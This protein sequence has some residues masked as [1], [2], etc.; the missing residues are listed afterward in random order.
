MAKRK[1]I[2]VYSAGCGCCRAA[3]DLVRRIAGNGHDV[4]VLNMHE[5]NVAEQAARHAISSVP[6]V[7]VD[8]HLAACCMGRDVDENVLRLAIIA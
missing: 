8:G 6:A 5:P 4:E 7:V 1:K 3:V 2:E